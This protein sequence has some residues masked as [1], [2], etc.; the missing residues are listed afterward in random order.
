MARL[1]APRVF[2][3]VAK[4]AYPIALGLLLVD[5]LLL[6]LDL[7]DPARFH[8]MLRVFKP[9]S[10][11]SFGTWSLTVFSLPLTIIVATELMPAEW[12]A[13]VW[14]RQLAIVGGLL[15]ALASALYKGVL[16]STNAQPG[17]RD[18]RW[19]A[20]YLTNSAFLL[21]CAQLLALSVLLDQDRAAAVLRPALAALLVLH[22]IFLGLL[23]ADL[24]PALARLRTRGE[25]CRLVAFVLGGGILL[26]LG[27]LLVA[28][29]AP[30]MLGAVG[31]IL[32]GSL[33]VRFEI[34]RIPHAGKRVSAAPRD[35]ARND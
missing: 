32:L 18:A 26:P 2:T 13:L 28:E 8:H 24:R 15:P 30:V 34:I 20:A 10:P 21:G 11:M 6:V 9:S 16:L 23:I 1:A 29:S 7:G 25:C 33:V 12:V 14:L 3:S 35:S 17:W 5:L 27:L 31:L 19:L 4:V 22:G